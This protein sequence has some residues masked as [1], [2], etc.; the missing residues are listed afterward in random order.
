MTAEHA[1]IDPLWFAVIAPLVL[2]A[3]MAFAAT[4]PRRI[5]GS[6]RVVLALVAVVTLA[7]G[8]LLIRVDPPGLRVRVDPSAEPLMPEN[9]PVRER[10]LEAVRDFGDDEV[11]VVAIISEDAFSESI[12]RALRRMG[13][14]VR[15]L[16][17]VRDVTSLTDVT[18]FRFV[19]EEDWI[20]VRPLLEAIPSD[21]STL[22]ALR[23]RALGDPLLR[24][25]VVSDDGTTAALNVSFRKMTDRELIEHDLDGRIARIVAEELPP[26]TRAHIA[27]RPHAKSRVYH[28]MRRDLALL[29]PLAILAMGLVLAF[30]S[31][32]AAGVVLPIGVALIATLWTFGALVLLDRPLT[33]LTT[34]LGPNL[35]VIGSVYGVHFLTRFYEDVGDA[36][37]AKTAALRC[38]V[39]VRTPVLVSGLTTVIGFGSLLVTDV[40]AVFDLGAFSVLGVAVTTLLSLTAMP[41][42]AA[43]WPLPAL[44]AARGDAWSRLAKRTDALL[45]AWMLRFEHWSVHHARSIAI[46]ALALVAASFVAIPHLRIDTDYL[47]FFRERS[48]VRRDFS[49]VNERLAGGV[50]L[51]VTFDGPTAGTFRKPAALAVVEAVQQRLDGVAGVTHTASL[52]DTIRRL[53]RAVEGDDPAAER[54]PATRGALAELIQMVPKP[55]LA[56][57]T[58]LDQQRA[59]LIVRTGT[60]GSSAVLALVGRIEDVLRSGIVPPEITAS[61]TG[62]AL[63][64][65]RSADHIAVQQLQSVGLATAVIFVLVAFGLRSFWLGI[66]AMV[67]NVVPVLLFFGMLGVGVAPLSLPTSLI[68]SVALGISIDDTMHLLAR[69]REERARGADAEEATRRACRTVGRGVLAASV[70]LTMGFAVIALS[71]FATLRQFGLLSAATMAICLANDLFL[72]PALL[73]G[74]WARRPVQ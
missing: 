2:V 54:L 41:A 51:Y 38:V 53:N 36:P 58:T 39:H 23:A 64:L 25:T 14:R 19:A 21:A 3:A 61:V 52:A 29:V 20:E 62:N 17:G 24:R 49:A 32:R 22:A 30:V 1:V 18:T 43:L 8:A 48:D 67:P 27:G 10:H 63:L 46:S 4:Q 68:A 45:A 55:D 7:C 66:V 72:L 12:L 37:D 15:E 44:D 42:A 70:M 71:D 56:R 73:T 28:G 74:R 5:V 16:P 65:S 35:I 31:G 59:N 69:W 57:L 9:D 50:L 60:V 26:G 13:E 40:P 6:P 34:L 33:I 11:Y 47:S